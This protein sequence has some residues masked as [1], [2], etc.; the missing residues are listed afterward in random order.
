MQKQGLGLAIG[1][2][3]GCN[4]ALSLWPRLHLDVD[5]GL[6]P[7]HAPL[8]HGRAAVGVHLYVYTD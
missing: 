5:M 7:H 2:A 6:D 3:P 1:R 4:G 8:P